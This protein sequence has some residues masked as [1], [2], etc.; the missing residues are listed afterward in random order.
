MKHND[1]LDSEPGQLCCFNCNIKTKFCEDTDKCF[2]SP[3]DACSAEDYEF[4]D[5]EQWHTKI[6]NND[7]PAES[8]VDKVSS[9]AQLPS[10]IMPHSFSLD[11]TQM[12]LDDITKKMIHVLFTLNYD[13]PD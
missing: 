11:I 4:D 13:G 12:I 3:I 5:F 6:M 7:V 2:L 9:F 10:I 1:E 8:I